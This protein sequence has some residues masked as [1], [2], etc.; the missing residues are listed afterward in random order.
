MRKIFP[1]AVILALLTGCST[2]SGF[3]DRFRA[4]DGSDRGVRSDAR[5]AYTTPG[6]NTRS[7]PQAGSID[8]ATGG[9]VL[10]Y[11]EKHW[12]PVIQG[13]AFPPQHMWAD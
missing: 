11:D 7:Y 9:T 1:A 8:P 4:G 6:S 5:G 3:T 12:P 2:I 10:P 13:Q